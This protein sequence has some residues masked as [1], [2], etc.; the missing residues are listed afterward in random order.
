MTVT[1][2]IVGTKTLTVT[3]A[4]AADVNADGTV[5]VFDLM[6]IAQRICGMIG[7]L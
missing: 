6:K 2:S 7:S 1:Q 5:D 3:Q 4:M